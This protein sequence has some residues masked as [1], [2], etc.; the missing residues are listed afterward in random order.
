MTCN[1]PIQTYHLPL[2]VLAE[3]NAHKCKNH[4]LL[5]SE[6][7][8][9]QVNPGFSTPKELHVHQLACTDLNTNIY[10]NED[11]TSE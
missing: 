7:K 8:H 11:I 1:S 10:T 5:Q 9:R 4:K 2:L 6:I 3:C